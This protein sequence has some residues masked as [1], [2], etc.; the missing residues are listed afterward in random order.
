MNNS[1]KT[2]IEVIDY[3]QKILILS[4]GSHPDIAALNWALEDQ[5]KSKVATFQIDDFNGKINDFD[6]LIFYKPTS[7]KTLMN[8]VE[9]SRHAPIITRKK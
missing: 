1:K 7:S 2:F 6:L 8:V 5:L 4:S 3:S 9:K